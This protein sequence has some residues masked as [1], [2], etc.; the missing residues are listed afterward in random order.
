MLAEAFILRLEAHLR[1]S[2]EQD[3]T[4][5]HNRFVPISPAGKPKNNGVAPSA[6]K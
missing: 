2:R 3:A 1:S 5:R 6:P 4:S